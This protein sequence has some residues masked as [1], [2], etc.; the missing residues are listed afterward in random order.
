MS[1][2]FDFSFV[3]VSANWFLFGSVKYLKVKNVVSNEKFGIADKLAWPSINPG[4]WNNY[5][6]YEKN[7]SNKN[8]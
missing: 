5:H 6:N 7:M 2:N 3:T 8:F 1:I 4:T